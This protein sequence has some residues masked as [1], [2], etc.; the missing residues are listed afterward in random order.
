MSD[1]PAKINVSAYRADSHGFSTVMVAKSICLYN[2]DP[3]IRI[4]TMSIKMGGLALFT[5]HLFLKLK[6]SVFIGCKS[7]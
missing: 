5:V 1:T 2:A 4:T 7:S 3:T 6:D